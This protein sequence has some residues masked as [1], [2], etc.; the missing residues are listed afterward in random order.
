MKLDLSGVDNQPL[1]V[2][3]TLALEAEE[4]D[5]DLLAGVATVELRLSVR[6]LAGCLAAQGRFAVRG[7]L[8]C[9]RCLEPVTWQAEEEVDV[10]LVE[11]QEPAG[12]D[13]AADEPD[14]EVVLLEGGT[15]DLR[16]LAAEQVLLALPMRILCR[17][18]CAGLCPHCGG[19]RNLDGGCRCR[20]ATDPRWEGLR[21]LV[22]G[23]DE[24]DD[25]DRD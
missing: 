9:G 8:R 11:R 13:A 20:P 2:A 21:D 5:R 25:Q 6:R 22:A 24:A 12:P 14:R 3:E 17:D 4:V 15:L 19:N 18:D 1:E 23:R 7:E 10:E 16:Q